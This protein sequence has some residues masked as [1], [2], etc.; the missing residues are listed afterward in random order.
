VHD[1]AAGQGKAGEEGRGCPACRA[2]AVGVGRLLLGRCGVEVWQS[3]R[4]HPPHASRLACWR[5]HV[6]TLLIQAYA[7]GPAAGGVGG[8]G[9]D[10]GEGNQHS[11]DRFTVFEAQFLVDHVREPMFQNRFTF[12]FPLRRG[13]A[14]G[15]SG[16]GGG[17]GEACSLDAVAAL[18]S[19]HLSPLAVAQLWGWHA[20]TTVAC[21]AGSDCAAGSVP[22]S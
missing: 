19:L 22:T 11:D 15:S 13:V 3:S 8:G 6:S 10:D 12:V 4:P 2:A 7:S 20:G 21:T 16:N 9:G 17:G 14:S 1:G 18:A 5:R